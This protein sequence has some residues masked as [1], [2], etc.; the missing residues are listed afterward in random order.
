MIHGDGD[1]KLE[2]AKNFREDNADAPAQRRGLRGI[3]LRKEQG[4][5][6]AANAES[7]V[8]STERFL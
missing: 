7:G 2:R 3:G 5:F 4:E 6:I 1:R 8:R